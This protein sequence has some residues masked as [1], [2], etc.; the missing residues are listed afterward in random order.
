MAITRMV[1][2]SSDGTLNG[3]S[4]VVVVPAPAASVQRIIR[5]VTIANVDTANVVASL[6]L[7]NGA[8]RRVIWSGVMEPGDTLKYGFGE[9]VMILDS[10]AKSVVAKLS[11]AAAT[12]NPDFMS[13]WM[14]RTEV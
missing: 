4:E 7:A 13:S 5:D 9:D 2:G 3:S 8:A 14:D 11:G 6:Q 10:T 12:S 1:P